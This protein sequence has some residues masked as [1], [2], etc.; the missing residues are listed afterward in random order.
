MNI[1]DKKIPSIERVYHYL[2]TRKR[3]KTAFNIGDACRLMHSTV[4]KD[5]KFLRDDGLVVSRYVV[6]KGKQERFK[7]HTTVENLI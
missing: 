7:E 6:N 5:I 2:K 3:P 1:K 4:N